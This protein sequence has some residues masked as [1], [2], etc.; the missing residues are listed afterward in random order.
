MGVLALKERGAEI[1]ELCLKSYLG[2]G[3]SI[4]R[5]VHLWQN[6]GLFPRENSHLQRD[7]RAAALGVVAAS[8][9]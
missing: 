2:Q 1:F 4:L 3:S 6:Q 8:P 9:N 7:T 5:A